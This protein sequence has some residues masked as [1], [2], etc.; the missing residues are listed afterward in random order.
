MELHLGDI[1]I[2]G[3]DVGDEFGIK[4]CAALLR[5]AIR[6]PHVPQRLRSAVARVAV[7]VTGS[8]PC[9]WGE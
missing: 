3:A 2:V 7:T 8:N 4:R 5:V 1:E 6:R 9:T